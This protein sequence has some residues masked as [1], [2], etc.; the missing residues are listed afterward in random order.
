MLDHDSEWHLTSCF[1]GCVDDVYY[2]DGDT[3]Y[4]GKNYKV[5]NGYHYISRTFWL[6]EDV[7]SRKIFLSTEDGLSRRE[8]ILYDFSLQV[9]DSI[10][11]K[12]P[13]SPFPTSP[14]F[15]ILDSI[16]TEQLLDGFDYRF[17]Y[18]SPSSTSSSSEN[19]IWIEGIGSLSLINAPGG[20]PGVND[21]GKLSCY[22]NEGQLIYTQLDSTDACV[23][24]YLDVLETI[25]KSTL[26]I[27][28]NPTKD[29][30]TI[31]GDDF[32]KGGTV[33]FLNALGKEVKRIYVKANTNIAVNDLKKGVYFVNV[34]GINGSKSKTLRLMIQ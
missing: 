28:P 10:E 26:S 8:D 2:T 7:Q 9:G 1:T 12:N 31:T 33:V 15:F 13:L 24:I 22:F 25:K 23:P 17:F 21:A 30:I 4:Y 11:I 18:L 3:I 5:L 29:F 32:K 19:P 27:F 34:N 6:R 16:R 20:T 14:G